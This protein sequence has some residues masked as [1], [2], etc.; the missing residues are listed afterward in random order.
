MRAC[1]AVMCEEAPGRGFFAVWVVF[2][3]LSGFLR[4]Y[5][6]WLDCMV[7]GL[8]EVSF[9]TPS[10]SRACWAV[11]FE[12]APGRGFF[13]SLSCVFSPVGVFACPSGLAWLFGTRSV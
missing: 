3:P 12:E 10:L 9:N 8:Y 11:M 6:V 5:L 7:L 4:A 13:R 1:W 2:F